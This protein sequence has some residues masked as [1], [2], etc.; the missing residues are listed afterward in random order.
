[1]RVLVA[2][3]P[4]LGHINPLIPLARGLR[5]AGHEVV[6]ATAE[7]LHEQL[8][9]AG[10]ATRV[11][12]PPFPEWLSQ[13]AKRTRGRPGDGIRPERTTQWFAPRLFGEVGAALL[14]DDL[15]AV[16][17]DV[18][19]DVVLF[20]SRCSAAP[21][22][23]RAVGALPVHRAVTALDPA[24]TEELVSDAVTP[25]W[26]EL[27]L[28]PPSYAG[29]FDGLTF[30]AYPAALDGIAQ[31]PG[32]SVHRLRPPEADEPAPEWLGPWL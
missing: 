29:I 15:L 8:H 17:L 19:P 10:F 16:A 28:D 18:A 1:V 6:W 7:P 22:V 24:M 3:V 11:A 13:L 14:V 12:G 20:D 4:A 32:V 9:A 23:A 25:L 26:R 27:G 30:A 31:Y 5:D 2:S 21:P